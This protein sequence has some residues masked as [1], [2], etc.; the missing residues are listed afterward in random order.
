[1]A[2]RRSPIRKKRKGGPRRGR[3]VDQ[4]YLDWIHTQK[5]VIF[6]TAWG[7]V[8]AHHVRSF[9]SMKDDTRTIPLCPRHHR[10]TASVAGVICVEQGK[11]RFEEW[12]GVN[13][14]ALI[15]EHQKRYTE[16]TGRAL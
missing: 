1:M 12:Y 9:G 15:L 8:E 10:L 2:L 14:E 5:C 3:V 13:L 11:L 7:E 6:H 4:D 16:E